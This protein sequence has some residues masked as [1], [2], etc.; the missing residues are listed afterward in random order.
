MKR[1]ILCSVNFIL[2][3]SCPEWDNAEGSG[4]AEEATDNAE[5]YGNAEEATDKNVV[6]II[7]FVRFA[8]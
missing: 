2:H 5:G 7:R 4:N 1:N 6:I 3:K 8:C